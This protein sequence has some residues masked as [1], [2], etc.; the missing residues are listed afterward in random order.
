MKRVKSYSSSFLLY[1]IATPI[2]NL[3]EMTP[4]AIEVLSSCDVVACEDT[5]VTS[6]LLSLFN[7]KGKE[8]ISLREHNE[9]GMSELVISLVKQGKNVVYMSDAGYPTIS[10]PGEILVNKCIDNDIS[11]SV[12]NGSSALLSGLIASNLSKEHFLF[13][14]FLNAK[15]TA[16]EKELKELEDVPYTIV[17]YEAPHRIEAT[18]HSLASV[19]GD[20]KVTLCREL[21]KM[22]EEYIYG[23]VN[24]LLELDF[25]TIIGE[26]VLVVEGKAK[27]CKVFSDSEIEDICKEKLETGLSKKEA[28]EQIVDEYKIPKNQ[29]YNVMKNL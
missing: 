10:D 11:I 1:L 13:Y 9:V 25:T 27:N 7:I 16:R 4:R 22:N 26:I 12:I 23:T 5:R 29:V 15:K 20:R 18:L 19:L 3:K 14:G 6:K 21:T 17:F 2:G 28:I 8:L 24:E